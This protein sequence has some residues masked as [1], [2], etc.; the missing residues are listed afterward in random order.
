MNSQGEFIASLRDLKQRSGLTYRQL[1]KRATEHGKVL[2]RSTLADVLAGK[3]L[4]APDVLDAFVHACGEGD[5]ADSWQQARASIAEPVP[6]SAS[7]SAV[8]RRIVLWPVAAALVVLVSVGTWFALSAGRKESPAAQVPSS[9]VRIRPVAAPDLCLTDGHVRDGRYGSL[10]AVQRPCTDVAPQT[11]T[12][13]PVGSGTYR[14][15]WHHPQFGKGCLKVLEDGLLEP[16]DDCTKATPFTLERA[17]DRYS[18][19]VEG[20]GCVGIAG[21]GESAEALVG[22]CD[23]RFV[24]DAA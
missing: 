21:T 3:R 10:V 8:R 24:I 16:W 11:T 5:Q 23:Q 6:A 15:A 12:L 20:R 22:E 7:A 13:E 18:L 19:R 14:I 4:P 2:A 1:E 17:E 9:A